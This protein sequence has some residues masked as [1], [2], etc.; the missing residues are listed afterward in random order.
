MITEEQD[1]L[2][3][4][5]TGGHVNATAVEIPHHEFWPVTE[6]VSLLRCFSNGGTVISFTSDEG[7][8]RDIALIKSRRSEPSEPLNAVLGELGLG[9][10]E[11]HR[12]D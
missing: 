4:S 11:L 5:A 7:D 12:R 9:G 1:I 3:G 2:T 6:A 10:C 8:L